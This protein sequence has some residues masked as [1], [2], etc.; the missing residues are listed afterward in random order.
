[1]KIKRLLLGMLVVILVAVSMPMSAYAEESDKDVENSDFTV[2]VETGLDGIAIEGK[3]MPVTV[4]IRNTGKDF[5]GILRIAVPA[6]YNQRSLAYEKAVVIPSGG[7]KSISML[8][9]DIDVISFLRIELENDKGKIVYSQQEEFKSLVVGQNAV[10]GILSNDYTGLNYFDGVSISTSSGVVAA[11]IIQLTADNIPENSDGLSLCHY[12]IID[13]YNTSQ[14]SQEQRNAIVN[15]VAD[16]GMLIVGTGSKA[17]TTLEGFQDSLCPIA[18][19]GL[20]KQ[21]LQVVSNSYMDAKQVDIANLSVDG[22]Q[23]VQSSIAYGGPAWQRGYGSGSVLV[24]S[25][26]LAMEPIASWKEI[27]TDLATVILENAGTDTCYQNMVY[28]DSE[29]YDEWMMQTAVQGTDRNKVPNALLY[30]AIFLIYVICIGPVMYLI[31]KARDKR[32]KMWIIM[33]I[34][35]LGFTVIV[36][37]TSMI[38]RIHKPFIDSVSMVEFNNGSV[39]TKTYMTVQSPKGKA[40]AIDFAKGYQNLEPWNDD[41]GYYDS[42]GTTDYTYAVRQNGDTVQL[43]VEKTMAFTKQN[44]SSQKEEYRAGSGIDTSLVCSLSGFEGTVTNNTGYDL[45]NVVVCY[46]EEYAY[47]G[48]M[49]NGE[50]QTVQRSQVASLQSVYYDLEQWM[51]EVPND[52]IFRNS[53][54]NRLLQ[55]NQNVYNILESKANELSMNQGMVF[56]MIDN[57]DGQLVEGKNAKVYSTAVA[58][59]YFYQVVEE[60]QNYSMF[61]GDINEYMVGGSNISYDSKYP[62]GFDYFYDTEDTDLYGEPEMYV[63]YD[64][65]MLNLEGAQLLN[66]NAEFADLEGDSDSMENED[67]YMDNGY[68]EDYCNVQLYNYNTQTYEDA[69]GSIGMVYDLTPYLNEEGWMQVRYYVDDTTDTWGYYA[70]QISLIGGEQ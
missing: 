32:E 28:G 66:L 18:V 53:E 34:I 54:A 65:G 7:E 5:S 68:G 42:V 14:L 13:N 33:P 2:S 37:G 40:Y 11:K 31:L 41:G 26:D 23:D 63:L 46:N 21:D 61:I 55:D 57:Y 59:S 25:Y 24:L 39:Q 12:I 35:A 19:N 38:Y 16:G 10:V 36:Y 58:I 3:S 47:L 44:L 6:T 30:A 62:S 49:K 27:H 43:Q 29:P 50:T 51:A 17:S 60:Y 22:W 67:L 45:K 48:D 4:T 8:L 70:P 56:G 69:F 20:S 1:M 15:W 64:F 9:P 52:T